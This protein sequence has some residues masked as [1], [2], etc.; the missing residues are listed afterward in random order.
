MIVLAVW[1]LSFT[2]TPPVM[3][4]AGTCSR[5]VIVTPTRP[6]SVMAHWRCWAIQDVWPVSVPSWRPI[7]D[8]M[9]VARG[10]KLRVNVPVVRD[11]SNYW[12]IWV[13]HSQIRNP[14]VVSCVRNRVGTPYRWGTQ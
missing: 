8:S 9:R 6:D 7:E 12:G 4:N 3:D 10:V 11:T 2:W 1:L 5:P 13:W 14:N